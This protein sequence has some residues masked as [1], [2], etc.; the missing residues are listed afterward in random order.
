MYA[1]CDFLVLPTYRE[2]FPN[3]VLEAAAMAVPT[4]ATRVPGCTDAVV[5]GVTGILVPPRDSAELASA[6]ARYASEAGLRQMHGCAARTRVL[7]DFRPEAIYHELYRHYCDL[8]VASE[9]TGP[10]LR[11]PVHGV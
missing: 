11:C 3:V 2:G 1:A 9:R 10:G 7:R 4:V 5:D 8:L 6:M